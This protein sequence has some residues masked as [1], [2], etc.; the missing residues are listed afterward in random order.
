MKRLF[1]IFLAFLPLFAIGQRLESV[2]PPASQVAK[3]YR[4][5]YRKLVSENEARAKANEEAGY[6]INLPAWGPLSQVPTVQ[7]V[8]ITPAAGQTNWGK[9]L[10]QAGIVDRMLSQARYKV[11]FNIGD[12]GAAFD[13]TDLQKGQLPGRSY[14]GEPVAPDKNGHGTHV[15]GIIA[16]RDLGVLWPLVDAGFVTFSGVQ[17]L[18]ASG[19]GSFTSVANGFAA[20]RAADLAR[21]KLG[22]STVWNG[23]F[24]GGTQLIA[25]VEKELKAS[26][27]QGIY[28]VFAA[29]N[30]GGPVNYPGNSPYAITAASLDQSL[31]ASSF[32]SRGPEIDA[33]GPGRNINSTHLNNTYVPLSGTSM[34]SPF[35]AAATG[36]MLCIWGPDLLPNQ[37]AIER[38]YQKVCSDLPPV[39]KDDLTGWGIALFRA[40]LDTRPDGGTPPPPPPPPVDPPVAEKITVSTTFGNVAMRYAFAG[41]T[42]LRNLNII[43]LTLSAEGAT[44]E[45][46]HAAINQTADKFFANSYIAEIPLTGKPSEIG[47][48]GAAYWTGTFLN[49]A[50]RPNKLRVARIVAK[51]EGVLAL[52]VVLD[53]VFNRFTD[54]ATPDSYET[55]SVQPSLR[56]IKQ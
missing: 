34:G 41:E 30:T 26:T 27:E 44:A 9:E 2:L 25:E 10:L 18:N 48:Y 15:A 56:S 31:V 6:Q 1:F 24:G 19:G 29:G 13:H 3:E 38:Y 33:G 42:M 11:H 8:S 50:G 40:I 46:A 35:V 43:E 12:T 5:T 39:G 52:P 20:E 17:F 37:G 51:A 32:S 14:I 36:F 23:S 21:K 22:I 49:Y 55:T 16:A 47:L 7:A 45:E 53:G 54:D 28:F 4:P